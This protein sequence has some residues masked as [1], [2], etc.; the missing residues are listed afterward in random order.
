M[1]TNIADLLNKWSLQLQCEKRVKEVQK[2][3]CE[4]H[5][6]KGKTEEQK[7]ML[8]RKKRS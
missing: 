7:V 3:K 4:G 1:K 8:A 6:I 5:C 2:K